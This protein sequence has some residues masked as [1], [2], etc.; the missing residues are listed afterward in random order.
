MEQSCV[1]TVAFL[2]CLSVRFHS[3]HFSVLL[4]IPLALQHSHLLVFGASRVEIWN[5]E[6]GTIVQKIPSR[7]LL[8]NSP[9]EDGK[10]ILL[11]ETNIMG[12]D[13]VGA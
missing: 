6:T 7:H 4:M 12:L 5:A 8:L 3:V 1:G 9:K 11:S 10:I 2:L 13:F